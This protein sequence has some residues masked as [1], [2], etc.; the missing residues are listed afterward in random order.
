MKN[1]FDSIVG[2]PGNFYKNAEI[3]LRKRHS[4]PNQVTL[5]PIE[6]YKFKNKLADIYS[7]RRGDSKTG[8]GLFVRALYNALTDE[9][10]FVCCGS[11]NR[12]HNKDH[13]NCIEWLKKPRHELFA[14]GFVFPPLYKTGGTQ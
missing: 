4:F 2:K 6:H 8:S 1:L 10:Q 11:I 9:F 5:G 13:E 3:L 14:E 7:V 12:P